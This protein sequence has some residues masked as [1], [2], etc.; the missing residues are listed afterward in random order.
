M[1]FHV[2]YDQ[3]SRI[4]H[5]SFFAQVD[6]AEKQAAAGQVAKSYGHLRPLCVLEDVRRAEIVMTPEERAAFGAFVAHLPGVSHARVAV[7][8][9]PEHNANVIIDSV[10]QKEGLVVREF[11]TE[12]AALHWFAECEA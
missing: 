11:V 12:A 3:A 4:V 1:G 2:R 9:T 10:A 8:H 5:L 6:L 7:L